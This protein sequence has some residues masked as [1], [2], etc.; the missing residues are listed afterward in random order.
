[1]QLRKCFVLTLI[2]V[3]LFLV[4]AHQADSFDNNPR[5]QGYL[6]E[7]TAREF[8]PFQVG[9]VLEELVR[10]D[11]QRLYPPEEYE[12]TG[13]LEMANAEGYAIG[14]IDILIIRRS[15]GKAVLIGEAKI[16]KNLA[17]GLKKALSQLDK[18]KKA[19]E[20]DEVAGFL[21]TPEPGR[22]FTI[23]QFSGPVEYKTFGSRSAVEVGFDHEID[24]TPEEGRWLCTKLLDG[25]FEKQGYT[26]DPK[27]AEL[28]EYVKLLKWPSKSA[29]HTFIACVKRELEKA[30]PHK[31]YQSYQDVHYFDKS[32]EDLGHVKVV[33][34]D[35][36]LGRVALVC[37]IVFG[38]NNLENAASVYNR[39]LCEF[40]TA[41]CDG[42]IVRMEAEHP[43]D[44]T[45]DPAAFDGLVQYESFGPKGAR[46]A[47]FS[48]EIDL[49]NEE[50]YYI[51]Y[52]AF[53]RY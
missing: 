35:R 51:R 36:A 47:G 45:L 24:I 33:I 39:Y 49:T 9:Y 44:A 48:Q 28:V 13:G 2:T 34:S 25:Y 50:I 7:L 19:L 5:L 46:A 16:W 31:L 22:V 1:V 29:K 38:W 27:L 26:A 21:Y 40:I 53:G 43:R 18:L 23:N 3:L 4:P 52:A 32:G 20:G 17:A 12:I 14:E 41:L 11:L 30:Y 6:D 37:N 15:D 8:V 42:K 10:I